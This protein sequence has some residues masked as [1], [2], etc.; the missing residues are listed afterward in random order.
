MPLLICAIPLLNAVDLALFYGVLTTMCDFWS[1]ALRFN[2]PRF[3]TESVPLFR[4]NCR[5]ITVHTKPRLVNKVVL[6]LKQGTLPYVCEV[7]TQ[8]VAL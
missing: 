3:R 2:A 4:N 8:G 6:L 5:Y 1:Y 7:L